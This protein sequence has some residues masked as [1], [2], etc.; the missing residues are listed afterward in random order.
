[1][2]EVSDVPAPAAARASAPADAEVVARGGSRA[3]RGVSVALVVTALFAAY[4]AFR[5]LRDIG[6]SFTP[7]G[8]LGF[9]ELGVLHAVHG[10]TAL[11]VYSR[12]GWFHPGPS[13]YYVLAPPYVLSGES[14]RSV[15]L[16]AWLVN[17]G[18]ALGA[19]A[20]VRARGG[21]L[22]ARVCAGALFLYFSAD[23]YRMINPWNPRM[24]AVPMFLFVVSIAATAD[25]STWSFVCALTTASYLVQVHLGTAPLLLAFLFAGALAWWLRRRHAET[26]DDLGRPAIVAGGLL[27][28]FW[29]GPV[30][31]QLTGRQGNLH[32]IASF[33]LHPPKSAGATGHSL[34]DSFRIISD[35][36]TRLPLGDVHDV[37]WHTD[38]A[39]MLTGVFV[40][41]VLAAVLAYRRSPFVAA[42]AATTPIG[43]AVSVVAATRVV[44]DEFPYL[45]YWT[46]AL[47]LPAVIASVWLLL[48]AARRLGPQPATDRAVAIATAVALVFIAG[49]TA[50]QISHR[51]TTSSGD[52][53]SGR[54]AVHRIEREVGS[55]RTPF[56]VRFSSLSSEREGMTV[57]IEKD[58]YRYRLAEP[59]H[60]YNGNAPN[61]VPARF[62]DVRPPNAGPPTDATY[63]SIGG[64]AKLQVYERVPASNG[65]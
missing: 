62:F 54:A 55:K 60:L 28:L 31:Q 2:T 57:Q 26:R 17:L 41:G 12:F 63:R 4:G 9:I 40:L 30:Y 22:L 61:A 51:R 15:F 33:Y 53:N 1:M 23:Y 44:G 45:F 59:L 65:G 16:G 64:D 46:Q 37:A 56:E 42:L 7:G 38:R 25:G 58:G 10:G 8:D 6:H 5:L 39:W 20:I 14:S 34:H 27:A 32:A 11:G 47:P 35:V 13:L 18:A 49:L 43:L 50:L 3:R 24:L 19:V 48:H 21:E 52:L 36:A 29:A